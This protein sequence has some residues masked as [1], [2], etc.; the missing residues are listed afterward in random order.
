[1]RR[2]QSPRLSRLP[3]SPQDLL[4][5]YR[6]I[7]TL[8]M[9]DLCFWSALTTAYRSLLRK[10]HYTVSPHVLLRRDVRVTKDFMILSITTSKTDQFGLSP[11][12]IVLKASPGSPLCPVYH[13]Y[14]LS[15]VVEHKPSDPFFSHPCPGGTRPLTYSGFS[16]KLKSL[17]ASIGL[18]P[19][20][21]SSHCIRHG[22]ASFL[23]SLNLPLE[24]IIQRG[25]WHS[26][27][28]SLYI[29]DSFQAQLTRDTPV[30]TKLCDIS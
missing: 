12:S 21:V 9:G 27:S 17:A 28:V 5:M 16:T 4:K 7:N 15:R 26:S 14:E 1:M 2:G 3:L 29:H 23:S 22:G 18:D 30:A 19:N 6:H 10:S 24:D 8:L 11:H 20:L 25:N 13:A